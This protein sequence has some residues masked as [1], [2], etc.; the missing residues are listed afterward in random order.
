MT[1]E[2]AKALWDELW[3]KG[4]GVYEQVHLIPDELSPL[5]IIL[6]R[7]QA[8]FELGKADGLREVEHAAK[9]AYG[10]GFV[11]GKDEWSNQKPCKAKE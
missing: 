2:D 4:C 8:A 7:L 6:K 3:G 5:P 10:R 1:H 11:A 9:I